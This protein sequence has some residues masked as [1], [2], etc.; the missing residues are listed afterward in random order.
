M[1]I[2]SNLATGA[3]ALAAGVASLTM[4]AAPSVASAQ[5]YGGTYYDP[6]KRDQTNRGTA[7]ALLGGALGAAIGSNAAA[8]KNRTEGALLGGALGAVAGAA[9][10]NNSAA[11][12]SGYYGYEPERPY[13]SGYYNQPY[14]LEHRYRANGY[15]GSGYYG[16]PY[17]DEDYGYAYGYGGQRLR[18]T[19]RAGPDGCALAESPVYMPDGRTVTRMVRVCMDSRGRYQVVD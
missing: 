8:G 9:V 1:Q 11:C 18:V 4:A 2:R 5:P 12:R 10:G 19:E 13:N 16:A 15:Y 14:D 3:L 17:A 7:G 6:C